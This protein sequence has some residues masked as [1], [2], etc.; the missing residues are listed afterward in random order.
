MYFGKKVLNSFPNNSWFL[1]VCSASLENTAGK[2]EIARNEHF[3]FFLSIF[4]PFGELS[5]IF[6]RFEIVVCKL[7]VWKSLQFVV[8]ERVN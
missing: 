7:S 3:S 1:P 4:F 2:G 6:I 8:W 5:A